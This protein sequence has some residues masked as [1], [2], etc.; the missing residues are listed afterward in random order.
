M[1]AYKKVWKNRNQIKQHQ[2]RIRRAILPL[3]K[4]ILKKTASVI[5]KTESASEH[6]NQI[7]THTSLNQ[8]KTLPKKHHQ[9]PLFKSN[10]KGRNSKTSAS[11][12]IN[13][14]EENQYI[15]FMLGEPKQSRSLAL[16]PGWNYRLNHPK[17][18]Q[19]TNPIRSRM[20]QNFPFKT[21][22]FHRENSQHLLRQN[23]MAQSNSYGLPYGAST[24]SYKQNQANS[25]TIY[26]YCP[27]F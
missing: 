23:S 2:C 16:K 25:P 7:S 10:I 21:A 24:L 9:N 17:Q 20:T 4:G 15:K 1:Y 11:K 26:G 14:E 22:Q 13:G 18:C 6:Q 12:I 19:Q 8:R 27:Q 3:T 5:K